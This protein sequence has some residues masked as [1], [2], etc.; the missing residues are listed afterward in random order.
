[1]GSVELV[2]FITFRVTTK[3]L[4]SSLK[5]KEAGDF[6]RIV[7]ES[8]NGMQKQVTAKII[9]ITND[10]ESLEKGLMVKLYSPLFLN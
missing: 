7:H 1:M 5:F 3:L 4:S 9:E 6:L 2:P 10:A 8:N